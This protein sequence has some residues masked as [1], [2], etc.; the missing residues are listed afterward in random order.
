MG[1]LRKQHPEDAPDHADRDARPS[2]ASRSSPASSARTR[3]WPAAF[4]TSSTRSCSG[5]GLVT[6]LLTAFYMFRLLLP[7]LLR[8]FRGGRRGGAPPARV[9]AVD[10]GAALRAGGGLGARRLRRRSLTIVQPALGCPR[11]DGAHH[12]LAT[13]VATSLRPGRHRRGLLVYLVYRGPCRKRDRALR[14][15]RCGARSKQ[16]G[17][18]SAHRVGGAPRR[19]DR[20]AALEARGRRAHR[21]GRQRRGGLVAPGRLACASS[22]PDSCATTRW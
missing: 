13:G 19:R 14:R 1:G 4:A 6:A 11:L 17:L 5:V 22:R 2:P 15:R 10:D 12:R 8:Q 18:D 20:D 9:A 21:R 16:V 7:D 3:S